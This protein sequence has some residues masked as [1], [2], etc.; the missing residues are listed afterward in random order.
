MCLSLVD[1]YS[2]AFVIESNEIPTV[3][4]LFKEHYMDLTYPELL[5]Q[6]LKTD[7][8]LS[9]HDIR[10]IE[11]DTRDQAKGRGFFRHRAGRIGVSLSKLACHSNPSLPSQSLIKRI[12]Y[13]DIF[14]FLTDATKHGCNHEKDAILAYE[15]K[16]KLIHD[17]FVVK[18]CGMVINKA[19]PWLHEIADF[20]CSCSCCGEGCGEVKCPYCI[21]KHDF[22]E[23]ASKPASCLELVDGVFY[24]KNDH[25]YY[26]QVQQQFFTTKSNYCDFVVCA[27]DEK[28]QPVLVH[29]RIVPDQAH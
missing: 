7:I 20:L 4:D 21:E 16:M 3:P 24:L 6:C 5:Q 10:T 29:Q 1:P 22:V 9:E 14:K 23:Y 8:R 18:D 26:Y 12:C 27:F 11:K 25:M 15:Q 13:P 19:S 2:N 28:N 17:N